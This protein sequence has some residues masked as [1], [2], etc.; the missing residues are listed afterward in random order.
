MRSINFSQDNVSVQWRYVKRN[1]GE[2]G[3]LGNFE[4]FETKAHRAIQKLI[5][6]SIYDEFKS[7]IGADRYERS[8]LRVD[9]RKGKYSRFF[10]HF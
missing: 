4:D 2:L 3:I 9:R 6:D 1:L 8:S 7:K 10:T 5:Q